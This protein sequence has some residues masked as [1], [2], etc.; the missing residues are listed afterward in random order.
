MGLELELGSELGLG[1][2][3]GLGSMTK[4]HSTASAL[5]VGVP[6]GPVSCMA[7]GRVVGVVGWGSGVG[8]GVMG[9]CSM[10][11]RWGV[12]WELA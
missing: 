5:E 1:L 7:G 11:V 4:V 9:W 3:L 10:G 6:S 12:G 2:G 8:V